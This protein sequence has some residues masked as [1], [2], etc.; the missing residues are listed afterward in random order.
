[1]SQAIGRPRESSN[2]APSDVDRG[3][4]PPAVPS[5]F[6][7]LFLRQLPSEAGAKRSEAGQSEWFLES[8]RAGEDDEDG[9][10]SVRTFELIHMICTVVLK[11]T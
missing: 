5:D 2:W 8:S 4:R 1:M 6:P 7:G 9:F 11:L 10:T 3:T